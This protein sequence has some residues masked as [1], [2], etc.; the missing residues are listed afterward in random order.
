MIA[1]VFAQHRYGREDILA[2]M[3]KSTRPP[4]GLRKCQFFVEEG[5]L[6]IILSS[7]NETEL[8][9]FRLLVLIPHPKFS[10]LTTKY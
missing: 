9:S 6:P 8:V 2:M 5:Q 3:P 10:A 1:P 7:L 4:D